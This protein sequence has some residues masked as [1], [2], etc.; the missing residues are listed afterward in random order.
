MN[1]LRPLSE[2]TIRL[3]DSGAGAEGRRLGLTGGEMLLAINGRP[4]RGDDDTLE[5]RF[6]EAGGKPLVLT[7]RRGAEEIVVLG[8]TGKLG[9]WDIVPAPEEETSD[10]PP[11]RLDPAHLRNFEVMRSEA[12][13]YDIMP[14]VPPM[15]A[16]MASP[17]W[18][19]QMR[20]W[21]PGATLIAALAASAVVTPWL[22][23]AVWLAAGLYVRRA[24]AFFLRADRRGR[25]LAFHGVIAARTEA[26]AHAR[27]LARHPGDRNLFLPAPPQADG[28]AETA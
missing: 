28:E 27:H 5:K 9:R 22:A 14:A 24:G 11:R 23:A 26:E 8:H 6:E 15:M 18:L 12:G 4:F 19:L 3:R 17:V 7:F 20:L 21:A 10:D 25:G 1:D 2:S 16:M 13:V